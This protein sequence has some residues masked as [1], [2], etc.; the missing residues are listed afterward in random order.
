MAHDRRL[1]RG[2]VVK[3][4]ACPTASPGNEAPPAFKPWTQPITRATPAAPTEV[5]VVVAGGGINGV[6]IARDLAGRGYSVALAEGADLAAHTSS[7]STKLIHGG[8]RYLEHGAL[9][10]VRKSLLEREV[11]LR[12]A[13]HIMWPMRFMMPVSPTGRPAWMIRAGLF[14]YDQLAP[15]DV[16]PGCVAVDLSNEAAGQDLLPIFRKAFIYSDGWVDDARLVVVA[17]LDAQSKGAWIGSRTAV[18]RAQRQSAGWAITLRGPGGEQYIRSRMLVNATGP[19]ARR[20]LDGVVSDVP[21]SAGQQLRLVKGSHIVVRRC[22]SHEHALILQSSDRRVIFVIPYEQDFTLIGTTDIEVGP[23]ILNSNHPAQAEDSEVDYLCCEV[24]RYLARPLTR[25]DVVW[26]Y[27]GV[28]PLLDD[29]RG[30]PSSVTRDYRL[31]VDGGSAPMLSVWGGKLTTFR[32]LAEEA[33]DI[34]GQLL[35]E[36]RAA[37]T[38]GAV[39]PGG[40]LGTWLGDQLSGHPSQDFEAFVHLAIK[41]YQFLPSAVVRRM[42]RAYGTRIELVVGDSQSR[43][44]MGDE[45]APGLYERELHYLQMHEWAGTADDVLWRR[46]KMGLHYCAQ[47]RE[48][49]RAWWSQRFKTPD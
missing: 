13:P 9:G 45:V 20:F 47:E 46:S 12:S 8:L 32:R 34:A 15:R 1:A 40:D 48:R 6:G 11:L 33:G 19:W 35:G 4:S 44:D 49:V 43:A 21:M 38:R 7:S 23:A 31:E 18:H 17:A 26:S 27:A 42:A 39:L 3:T 29:A 36:Q 28:R 41:R 10:L 14:L 25:A 24:N 37:W 5:D 22:W 2:V 30:N 16:L